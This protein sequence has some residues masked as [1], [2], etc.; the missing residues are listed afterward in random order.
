[1]NAS[2]LANI[3]LHDIH[4]AP[5]PEF[6]PP[7]PGWWILAGIV[8]VVLTIIVW[9]AF[10][11]WR[12]RHQRARILNELN[13]LSA[14]SVEQ[15]ATRI[16][17]L[18]RRVALMCFARHDVASLSGHDWLAFLDRT[19]GN[20]EFVNGVGNILAIAP[21]RSAHHTKEIDNDALIALARQWLTHNLGRHA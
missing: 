13:D 11:T 8:L 6:W 12:R 1:M 3:D 16:S 18:L 2:P 4:G 9:R 5:P 10:R 7:A 20:G 15:L 19:G 17:M 21:Y 14:V